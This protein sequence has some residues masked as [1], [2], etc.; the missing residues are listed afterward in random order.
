M[1][2]NSY[3][4]AISVVEKSNV[5][6]ALSNSNKQTILWPAPQA[7]KLSRADLHIHST[8]SDGIPT[9]EQILKYT[10]LNTGLDVIA[11]TDHNVIDGSLRA[12][13]LWAKSSYRFDYI[14]GEEISTNEGHLLAL[15]IEKQIPS[16]LSIERSIDLIHDQG[17]LA[18]VVHPLHP[19]FRMSCQRPVLDRIRANKDLW[20]DGIETLN[21]GLCGIYANR[22]TMRANR[23]CYGWSEVG[24]S[25]AHTLNAIGRACT[26]FQGSTASDVRTTIQSGL[27]T[28]D[29]KLWH[30]NDFIVLASHQIN[31]RRSARKQPAA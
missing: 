20:L 7:E 12:R 17:G 24:N 19:L 31:K 3:S 10:E 16:H 2:D 6:I 4:R 18:I 13:D 28:P 29:G 5:E 26:L 23:Q 1:I 21:A 14:V 15:F 25:D 22:L 9:I 11:I 8:Y 30:V 27:S